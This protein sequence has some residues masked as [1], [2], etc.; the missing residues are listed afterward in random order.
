MTTPSY[1]LVLE[2]VRRH[3]GGGASHDEADTLSALLALV[4]D[5]KASKAKLA[6]LAKATAEAKEWITKAQLAQAELVKTERDLAA[7]KK[8]LANAVTAHDAR[9]AA[10][11]LAI[12]AERRAISVAREAAEKVKAEVV[13]LK[14][15]AQAAYDAFRAAV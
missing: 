2:N 1:D 9:L 15:K 12:D 13:A 4:N 5:P 10:D 11:R 14:A 3:S 7:L 8:Q 6:E